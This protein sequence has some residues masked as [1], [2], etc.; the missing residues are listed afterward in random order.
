[1]LIKYPPKW[2]AISESGPQKF[3]HSHLITTQSSIKFSIFDFSFFFVIV[4]NIKKGTVNYNETKS[5]S[6][7]SSHK[8]HNLL[9]NNSKR[10]E[11]TIHLASRKNICIPSPYWCF[12][13]TFV[14]NVLCIATSFCIN[15]TVHYRVHNSPSLSPILSQLNS[16]HILTSHFQ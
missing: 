12:V 10:K 3:L 8:L 14:V 4:C 15:P 2:L 7:K 11:R 5:L 16:V 6:Y 9:Y 13:V 1:V